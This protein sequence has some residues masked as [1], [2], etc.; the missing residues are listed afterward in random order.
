MKTKLLYGWWV[1]SVFLP[2]LILLPQTAKGAGKPKKGEIA[3]DRASSNPDG[4]DIYFTLEKSEGS[5]CEV[6][7]HLLSAVSREEKATKIKEA[8]NAQCDSFKAVVG[9]YFGTN[10][11]VVITAVD[12]LLQPPLEVR[13][14]S[15]GEDDTGESDLSRV[16]EG[17]GFHKLSFIDPPFGGSFDENPPIFVAGTDVYLANILTFPGQS[18][19]DLASAVVDDLI[20]NGIDVQLDSDSLGFQVNTPTGA[21]FG[22]GTTDSTLRYTIT[23]ESAC[24]ATAGDANASGTVNLSDIIYVVNYVFKGGPTPNPFCQGDA[25]ASGGVNL[26]DLIY[27]VNYVFKGGALPLPSGVCCP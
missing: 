13:K 5:K 27:L 14:I 24:T 4:G 19:Q 3:V 8:I 17:N 7:V 6:H 21:Y 18:L 20:L 11:K 26:S 15:K 25:N 23:H 16:G 2:L 10:R 12:D 1:W 22:A 9:D